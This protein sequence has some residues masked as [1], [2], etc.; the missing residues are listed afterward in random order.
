MFCPINELIEN[1][2]AAYKPY[3]LYESDHIIIIAVERFTH[4]P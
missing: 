4:K 3:L 2:M 1:Q